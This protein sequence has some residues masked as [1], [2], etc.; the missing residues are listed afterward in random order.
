[1]AGNLGFETY[2]CA[3][4]VACVERRHWQTGEVLPGGGDAVK[5][6]ALSNIHGEFCTVANEAAILSLLAANPIG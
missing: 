2:V 5:T 3:D 6:V 1:M 4:A